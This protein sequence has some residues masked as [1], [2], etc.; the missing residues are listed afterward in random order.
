MII[1]TP[2]HPFSEL[3]HPPHP[4]VSS[5]QSSC[6]VGHRPLRHGRVDTKRRVAISGLIKATEREKPVWLP[7]KIEQLW[8]ECQ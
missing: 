5:P 8:E 7:S 3:A 2:A 1:A 6:G 4:A